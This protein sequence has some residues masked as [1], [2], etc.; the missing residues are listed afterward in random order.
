MLYRLLTALI[1]IFWLTMAALLLR[2]EVGPGD[3]TLNAVPVAHVA[4]MML[5]HEQTS[6]L[7][8]YNEKLSVGRLQVHP[9]IRKED[10][11]RQ[12]ALSGSLQLAFPGMMRQ[13]I[14]W[15]GD[16]DL[17]AQLELQRF[18]A[19]VNF[20]D[21]SA[22]TVDLLVEPASHRL[23]VETRTGSQVIK[24][25]QYSLDENGATEWLREQ[26]IDPSLLKNLHNPRSAPLVVK[27][28]QSS[29]EVRGEKVDTYLVSAEQGEQTLLEAHVS[30]LGQILRVRTLVGYSAAPEDLVP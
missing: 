17:D 9:M 11:Q 19:S 21:P 8:I 2:K 22:Y 16:L 15:M 12:I 20:R 5:A 26:G 24:R 25:S 27:A 30:Q 29:L 13:R 10:G 23:T 14:T 1:V 3:T 6:D 18:K 4:K 7:Q 28:Q